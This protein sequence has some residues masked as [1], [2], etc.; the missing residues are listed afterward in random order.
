[1]LELA[2]PGERQIS[3]IPRRCHRPGS[4]E[5]GCRRCRPPNP[6][7]L[8]PAEAVGG[9]CQSLENLQHLLQLCLHFG[10]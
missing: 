3:V 7:S 6:L 1:M 4:S 9:G 5:L 8:N 2:Q 10:T